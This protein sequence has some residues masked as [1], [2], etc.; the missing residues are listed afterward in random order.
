M[1]YRKPRFIYGRISTRPEIVIENRLRK[2][3]AF[4]LL[5]YFWMIGIMAAFMI[6]TSGR[7]VQRNSHFVM[8]WLPWNM[9]VSSAIAADEETAQP[10]E[11][12]TQKGEAAEGEAN[13]CPE[14]P[15]C[16]DPAEF[17]L[18]GLEARKET[19]RIEEEALKD[20]RKALESYKEQIDEN[21]EKL[22]A[23]KKQIAEDLDRIQQV[24]NDKA[25]AD[26][27]AKT[28]AFEKKM[29]HMAAVYAKMDPEKAGAV[30]G[31]MDIK[32]ASEIISRIAERKASKLLENIDEAQAAK[33]SERL[34][35]KVGGG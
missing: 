34:A 20:E 5:R 28:A 10:T 25:S 23:L 17:V 30:L 33:I 2:T 26:E 7:A 35:H 24:K 1:I 19:L 4:I 13:P 3:A 15:E 27:R 31:K 9:V 21:L 6:L 12:D 14:C 16:P 11:G 32:V 22:E 29:S 18:Q 8:D